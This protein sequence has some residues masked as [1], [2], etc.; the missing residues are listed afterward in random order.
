MVL[1]QLGNY[2]GKSWLSHLLKKIQPSKSE[3]LLGFN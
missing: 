2:L 1:E 3:E